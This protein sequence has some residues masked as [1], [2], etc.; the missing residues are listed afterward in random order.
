MIKNKYYREIDTLRA[1]AVIAVVINHLNKDILP[2]GFLGVD[3]F[4]VISGFVVSA[5]FDGKI[6]KESFWIFIKNFYSRRIKRLYPALLFTLVLSVLLLIFFSPMSQSLIKTSLYV[7]LGVSNWSLWTS[8][9][10]YFSINAELNP[11]THT[12]SLG[13]EEQ[14]Y[15]FY[16]L[17]MF[18]LIRLKNNVRVA[19]LILLSTL[20]FILFFYLMEE[21]KTTAFYL[22]PP[23]VW[24]LL[25]GGMIFY[26]SHIKIETISKYKNVIASFLVFIISILFYFF[27]SFEV[28]SAFFI[29]LLTGICLFTIKSSEKESPILTAEPFLKIG[30]MSY[31]IYLIHWPVLAIVRQTVSLSS[32]SILISIVIIITLSFFSY[33]FIENK[34]KRMKNGKIFFLSIIPVI[35]GVYGVNNNIGTFKKKLFLGN[36]REEYSIWRDFSKK[37]CYITGKKDMRF[38]G[39]FQEFKVNYISNCA[40]IKNV[41]NTNKIFSFGNSHLEERLPLLVNFSNEFGY[42]LYFW[43]QS[44]LPIYP[45]NYYIEDKHKYKVL[46]KIAL[47]NFVSLTK[48]ESTPGDIIYFSSP[49][50]YFYL[51][52]KYQDQNVES[53]EDEEAFD[54]FLN[55]LKKYT[56]EMK[57]KGVKVIYSSSYPVLKRHITPEICYQPWSKFNLMCNLK[58]SLDFRQNNAIYRFVERMRA[59]SDIYFYSFFDLLNS[60]IN[61]G[62]INFKYFYNKNHLTKKGVLKFYDDFKAYLKS[63]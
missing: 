58:S 44:G 16:P 53:I 26:C 57:D 9:T 27:K 11:F 56:Q 50:R 55:F 3:M 30:L 54:I 31:S 61:D 17:L 4:F 36:E 13:V 48:K 35:V 1:I 40:L 22:S 34:F 21:D 18:G 37:T 52:R 25:I 42:D 6:D 20:S 24:Q 12:W 33:H 46:P 51:N 28:Q 7:I 32:S 41:K 62:S 8:S 59:E 47:M 63:I 29:T 15:F 2:G 23:R 43:G 39:E 60:R 49:L 45:G 5:S 38:L 10:D 19:L 14:F